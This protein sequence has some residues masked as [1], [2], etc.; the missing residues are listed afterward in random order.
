MNQ[1]LDLPTVT[2]YRWELFPGDNREGQ[3]FSLRNVEEC[4]GN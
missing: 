1:D 2:S 3:C 4:K